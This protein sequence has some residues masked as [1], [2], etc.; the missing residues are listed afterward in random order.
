MRGNS[1]PARLHLLGAGERR[2]ESAALNQELFRMAEDAFRKEDYTASL[3]LVREC[4]D[5][6][7]G[8][9]LEP[10]AVVPDPGVPRVKDGVVLWARNL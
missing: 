2:L 4:M 5:Q 10:V 6:V 1:E 8:S 7:P 3:E 9:Y